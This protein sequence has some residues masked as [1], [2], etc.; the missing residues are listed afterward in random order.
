MG[1]YGNQQEFWEIVGKIGPQPKDHTP[2]LLRKTHNHAPQTP[3]LVIQVKTY[4]K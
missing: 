2:I 4:T 1:I 3:H